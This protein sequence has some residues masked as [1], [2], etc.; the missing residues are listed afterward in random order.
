[1]RC[2]LFASCMF[3]VACRG[4]YKSLQPATGDISCLQKFRPV[5][6]SVLYNTTV[7]VVGKHLSG[8]LLLK[9]MPDSSLRIVFSSEM[10]IKFFDFEFS[11]SGEFRVHSVIRQMNRK[12]IINTLR[13]DFKLVLM[14]DLAL[15]PHNILTDQRLSYYV[16]SKG[17]ELNYY[18]TDTSCNTLVRIEKTSKRK[19][20]V[21]AVMERYINGVPDTIGITHRNF[22]F[23]IG[24]KRLE[25]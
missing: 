11:R 14:Q 16:F 12:A 23:N 22:N 17:A 21:R 3:L 8:L 15:A 2:L 10:G 9:H 5:I 19:V 1:M 6:G 20:K 25:R 24:L 18:I 4:P 13:K 7:D